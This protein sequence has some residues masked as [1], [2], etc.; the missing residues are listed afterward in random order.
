MQ[1]MSHRVDGVGCSGDSCSPIG[2]LSRDAV[3]SRTT[4]Q[5]AVVELDGTVAGRS[6]HYLTLSGTE[7]YEQKILICTEMFFY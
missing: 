4:R 6:L 2:Q 1:Y 3:A 7:Y 5:N